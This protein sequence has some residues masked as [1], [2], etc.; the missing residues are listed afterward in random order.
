MGLGEDILAAV[1]I[2]AAR[3]RPAPGWF[4]VER[5]DTA[6]NPKA[7]S[8][9]LGW[10]F[11]PFFVLGLFFVVMMVREVIASAATYTWQSVP[12][13]IV[14]SEVREEAER[15]LQEAATQDGILKSADQNA[16]STLASML[17]GFGF[18]QVE[19]Q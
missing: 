6:S 7:P 16:R 4:R 13:Q 12:C 18:T 8:R 17:K 15:Q 19:I 9:A 14:E 3:R 11:V 5:V 2:I 10:A 1:A